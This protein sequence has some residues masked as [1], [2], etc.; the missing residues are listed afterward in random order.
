MLLK[1]GRSQDK[2]L[3]FCQDG[4]YKDW[5]D[6]QIPKGRWEKKKNKER[7]SSSNKEEKSLIVQ[8]SAESESQKK[9][10]LFTRQMGRERGVRANP[11][12]TVRP[13]SASTSLSF[14]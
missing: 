3:Q 10:S 6:L 7:S 14:K 13:D 2:N 11:S 4:V 8:G 1:E 12:P 9:T 5:E